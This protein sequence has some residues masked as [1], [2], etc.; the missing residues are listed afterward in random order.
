LSFFISL[1]GKPRDRPV[2][3]KNIPVSG[4]GHRTLMARHTAMSLPRIAVLSGTTV[5]YLMSGGEYGRPTQ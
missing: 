2:L 4:H 1:S 3:G 5:G